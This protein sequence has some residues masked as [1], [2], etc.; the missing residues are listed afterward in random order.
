[1]I[2]AEI[3][4][5]DWNAY[6]EAYDIIN[7]RVSFY[8][9]LQKAHI[10]EHEAY[11]H[12][13]GRP[14]RILDAG[15]GTGNNAVLLAQSG[16][17]AAIHGIDISEIGLRMLVRKCV[18]RGVSVETLKGSVTALPYPD[19]YFDGGVLMM[20]VL[21]SIPDYSKALGEIS[22]VT[23]AGGVLTVSGPMPGID[24]ASFLKK[25]VEEIED[26]DTN[27]EVKEAWHVVRDVNERLLTNPSITHQFTAAELG[28]ILS[29]FGFRTYLSSQDHFYG[30]CC[31]VAAVK[32]VVGTEK[33]A[34]ANQGL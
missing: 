8:G 22:R 20:N 34:K 30:M 9:A 14:Q 26:I 12:S 16:L 7:S 29:R 10:A 1:M 13:N 18:E 11:C 33:A 17:A 28:E 31:F 3:T 23:R 21:Y 5:A 24:A 27:P 25:A 19:N 6:F 32:Q 15:C 4:E 2:Q